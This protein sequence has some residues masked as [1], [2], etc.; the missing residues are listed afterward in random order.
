MARASGGGAWAATPKDINI[1]LSMN[2]PNSDPG[3]GL[4]SLPAVDELLR[5]PTVQPLLDEFPRG[6]LV[7][8]IRAVLDRCRSEI[9]AGRAI[10]ADPR[11][12]ALDVRRQLQDRAR[13][14]LRRVINATGIVLHTG[15]GRAPL[16]AEA[17]AA[18]TE[19]AGG[20]CNLELDLDTGERGDRYAH[21]RDLL[22]ELTGAADALV[23]N[24][25]AAGVYLALHTLAAG[26][27]AVI[28]RG[29]LVEIGGS[30]R[31]PDIM[32]AAGCRMIEVGTTNRTRIGDYE[33]V[34]TAQTRVLLR[35]HPSNFRI[36][37]F[38]QSTALADLVALRD[39]HPTLDIAVVDDLGSG[40]LDRALA[41]WDEP[42]V[43][44]S[45]A[46][47]ADLVLFSGD[48]L[49]GGPQAGILVGRA[50]LVERLRRNPLTRALRPDKLALAALE[51][52]LRLYRDPDAVGRTLPVFAALTAS[53]EQ[54]EVRARQI[55]D[56]LRTLLP[57]A[58]CTCAAAE[59]FAG[60]GALPTH[61]F[62]T[63]IVRVEL[64]GAAPERLAA[65][66]RARETPIVARVHDG[67][68]VFDCRTLAAD[69]LE[70][71]AGGLADAARELSLA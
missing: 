57:A 41:P 56:Q 31:M 67:A 1:I 13:P 30:Y 9:R 34:V 38:V 70:L 21:A 54:L 27:E 62:P 65:A 53:A 2:P 42:A 10:D 49:L 24:N 51:A 5:H 7:C 23:V 35:V 25:N 48:K 52:T 66:L 47:G 45:V 43:R 15:L 14:S 12:L 44:D 32:T 50:E 18:L 39:A 4:R 6:E 28:S 60:G 64:N 69:E 37:G 59:T 22:C 26:H 55:V 40:L 46:A 71:V 58:R 3:A 16:A 29:Q 36:E 8:S 11:R 20:Y 63:W 19:L 17:V 33:R 61:R 68:L